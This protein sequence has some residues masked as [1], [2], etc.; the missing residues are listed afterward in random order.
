M[1][2]LVSAIAQELG[3]GALASIGASVGASEQQTQAVLAAALPALVA[4]M[5]RNTAQPEG[6]DALANAL[7]RD[8]GPNLMASLGPLA[9]TLLGAS[10]GGGTS[11][12]SSSGGLGSL[13]GA[14][15]LGGDHG[16]A[17]ALNG[18][19]ILGHLLGG[20]QPAVTDNVGRAAGLDAATVMKLLVALAPVVMSALGTV[21]QQQGLDAAGVAQLVQQEHQELAGAAPAEPHGL[22]LA[23]V[24]GA[25]LRSGLLSKLF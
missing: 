22:D 9:A 18:A 5:A 1:S 15:A 3:P 10:G 14:L 19:G 8:H 21:K 4:G 17:R 12:G 25:V 23:S 11:S 7:D 6:A 13:L 24:A 20:D 16:G 2:Q